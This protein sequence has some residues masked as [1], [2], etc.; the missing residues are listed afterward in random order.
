[1]PAAEPF[2]IFPSFS[3][4]TIR[5]KQMR[6]PETH[7]ALFHRWRTALAGTR[8]RTL[9]LTEGLTSAQSIRRT[10]GGVSVRY[11]SISF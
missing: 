2:G 5:P 9:S 7:E 4:H 8:A 10:A 11:S 6:A 3:W 1:M